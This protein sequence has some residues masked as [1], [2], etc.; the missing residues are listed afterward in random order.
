MAI[1]LMLLACLLLLAMLGIFALYRI[2]RG[3]DHWLKLGILALPVVGM[4][5]GRYLPLPTF[6]DGVRETL[7]TKTSGADFVGL[8]KATV[9][10]PPRWLADDETPAF[11]ANKEAWI[12]AAAPFDRLSVEPHP[13]VSLKGKNLLL[14][15][16]GPFSRRWGLA[17]SSVP[18]AKP[19]IPSHA[20]Y[21]EEIHPEVW[22]FNSYL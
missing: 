16:G 18:G 6:N 4:A 2:I 15:W 1:S 11:S 13:K 7:R 17:I 8:A 20:T 22:L 10:T 21:S 19:G 14:E 9:A 12:K 3:R 5:I